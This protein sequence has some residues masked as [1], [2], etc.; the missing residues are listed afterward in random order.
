M[1]SRITRFNRRFLNPLTVRL[2][3]HGS[4]VDLEHV[5]RTSGTRYH[6]PL[7]AFRDGADGADGAAGGTVTIALTYGPDVQWLRNVRA[8]GRCRM[9]MGRRI[10]T[11]GPPRTLDPDE[12]LS[13]VPQPQRA[14]LRWPIRCRDFIELPILAPPG[15]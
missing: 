9:R 8:A 3:G 13:R 11:L 5:G 6:T 15:T 12:G 14:L 2:A 4:I 7:M 1:P 10:L